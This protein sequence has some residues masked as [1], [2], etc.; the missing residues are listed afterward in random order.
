MQRSKGNGSAGTPATGGCELTWVLG[1][2]FKSSVRATSALTCQA[3]SKVLAVL[4]FF[5]HSFILCMR[6]GDERAGQ[7]RTL[8]ELDTPSTMYRS[9]GSSSPAL[10]IQIPGVWNV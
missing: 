5:L 8:L 6:K 3:T 9:G 4:S 7:R 2:E 10:G 1:T